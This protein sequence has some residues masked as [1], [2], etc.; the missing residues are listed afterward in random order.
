[1]GRV[2]D[3]G[4]VF[5]PRLELKRIQQGRIPFRERLAERYLSPTGVAQT[6]KNVGQIA[7]LLG[8]I[9]F[10]PMKQKTGQDA[11]K[12]VAQKRIGGELPEGMTRVG[13]AT[14]QGAPTSITT[15]ERPLPKGM[16]R[17]RAVEGQGPPGIAERLGAQVGSGE[18]KQVA[19]TVPGSI[20][21]SKSASLASQKAIDAGIPA[22]KAQGRKTGIP[23]LHSSPKATQETY[24]LQMELVASGDL[25]PEDWYTGPGILGRKTKRAMARR[26]ARNQQRAKTLEHLF[27][28]EGF[29]RV[30]ALAKGPGTVKVVVRQGAADE[31][32]RVSLEGAEGIFGAEGQRLLIEQFQN[33][34]FSPN[35]SFNIPLRFG[36]APAVDPEP[37]PMEPEPYIPTDWPFTKVAPATALAPQA[38]EPEPYVP[39]DRPAEPAAA[40]AAAAP[41]AAPV[42]PAAAPVAPAMTQRQRIRKVLDDI[43][44]P[45]YEGQQ[46]ALRAMAMQADTAEAQSAIMNAL[47]EVRIPSRGFRDLFRP[48]SRRA[49]FR[50]EIRRLFPGVK[51]PPAPM[52]EKERLGLEMQRKQLDIAE[53]QLKAAEE[54]RA[55]E[56]EE[57][58]RQANEREQKSKT[59]KRRR[60]LRAGRGTGKG[61]KHT[62]DVLKLEI[63][64]NNKQ[65]SK[66][67]PT[68][69]QY[70]QDVGRAKSALTSLR[71]Q[72]KRLQTPL[73]KNYRGYPK[74]APRESP[75]RFARRER[76]YKAAKAAWEKADGERKEQLEAVQ[77]KIEDVNKTVQGYETAINDV[78]SSYKRQKL[79]QTALNRLRNRGRGQRMTAEQYE[80]YADRILSINMS[81]ETN[82]ERIKSFRVVLDELA[83]KKPEAQKPRSPLVY[84]PATKD[85]KEE[86][87]KENSRVLNAVFDRDAKRKIADE[88]IGVGRVRALIEQGEA[89]EVPSVTL[90]GADGVLSEKGQRVLIEQYQRGRYQ[91]NYRFYHPMTFSE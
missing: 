32:P 49:A 31:A 81:D 40:P 35:R 11:A 60:A 36:G 21:I 42:A 85:T 77:K 26:D 53:Q 34:R 37:P 57:R 23:A 65:L 52:T 54:R 80:D 30:R 56:R 7:S 28:S 41:V 74:Q 73:K 16:S 48:Q 70:K 86:Q 3:D 64:E 88:R 24:Q 75:T 71:S 25:S 82:E 9:E 1:M 59:G 67:D 50:E 83:G 69:T 76:E 4:G 58:K 45:T 29:R 15:S 91:P 79:Y 38:M 78:Q 51:K 44:S 12:S 17:V 5:A 14:G 8:E 89:G 2:I 46:N 39:T 18:P 43:S 84:N 22:A 63:V 6:M 47:S 27:G 13:M 68:V 87:F 33:R 66:I 90:E 55:D 62:D 19:T 10:D 61:K 72:E 20:G